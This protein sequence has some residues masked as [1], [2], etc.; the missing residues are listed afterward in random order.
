MSE[1]EGSIIHIH[2]VSKQIDLK[3]IS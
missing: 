1:L 2:R 3:H